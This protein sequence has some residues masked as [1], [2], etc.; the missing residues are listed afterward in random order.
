[1]FDHD[2][3]DPA[4]LTQWRQR[5]GAAL[6]CYF[7]AGALTFYPHEY[8]AD[9]RKLVTILVFATWA[10]IETA[11]ATG[12]GQPPSSLM[13]YLRPAVF[14]ILGQMWGIE[15]VNMQAFGATQS[16]TDDDSDEEDTAP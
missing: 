4:A 10:V 11:T 14:L 15:I 3:I 13:V 5:P 7:F 12:L 16:S 2:R 8:N 6:K 1:M 9:T